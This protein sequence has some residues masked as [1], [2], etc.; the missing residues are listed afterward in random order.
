MGA[1]GESLLPKSSLAKTL[2]CQHFDLGKVKQ[3]VKVFETANLV[4]LKWL[5]SEKNGKA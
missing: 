5:K 4:A 3:T 1:K 2:K